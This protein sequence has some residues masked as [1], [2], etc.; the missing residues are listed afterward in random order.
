MAAILS[1][2]PQI[3]QGVP[4]KPGHYGPFPRPDRPGHSPRIGVVE[5]IAMEP[6]VTPIGDQGLGRLPVKLAEAAP[7]G[8]VPLEAGGIALAVE[9]QLIVDPHENG[10]R[11]E[12]Q[13]QIGPDAV[14]LIALSEP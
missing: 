2:Q 14:D 1:D 8:K 13:R 7:P 6:I 11:L 12:V 4:L 5:A 9:E 10:K 3:D